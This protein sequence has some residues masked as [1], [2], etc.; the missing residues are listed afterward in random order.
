MS[1]RLCNHLRITLPLRQ[2]NAA[3]PAQRRLGQKYLSDAELEF[4]A[5]AEEFQG[6]AG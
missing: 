2:R 1:R 3:R 4:E 5:A 6:V